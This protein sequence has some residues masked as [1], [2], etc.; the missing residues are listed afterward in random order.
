MPTLRKVALM[1]SL[2]SLI[3][4]S[5]RPI[6]SMIGRDLLLSTSTWISNHSKP[7]VAKVLI[8]C[9]GMELFVITKSRLFVS[10]GY[11]KTSF[12]HRAYDAY[13]FCFVVSR[14]F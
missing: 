12:Y 8:F 13:S 14:N 3:A 4:A 11:S 7:T 2:D 1:R 6:I 9:I 5:G 10:K